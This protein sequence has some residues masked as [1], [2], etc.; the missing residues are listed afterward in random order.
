MSSASLSSAEAIIRALQPFT[1]C[2]VSDALLKLKYRNGGF[3]AGPTM[4]SPRR[5]DGDTKIIGRAYTVKYARNDDPA[6][7]ATS[8]YVR[9]RRCFLTWLTGLQIDSVPKGSVVFI[10]VPPDTPNAAY[11]GLMSTRAKACGAVGSVIDGRI[12]DLREHRNLD[13]PVGCQVG[14]ARDSE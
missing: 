14:T 13:F 6:P 12:R 11:G 4:W 10:S 1:T 3:L 5:Q 8:H 9:A 2:D 7:K